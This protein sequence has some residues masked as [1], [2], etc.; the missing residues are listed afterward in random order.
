MSGIVAIQGEKANQKEDSAHAMLETL[1]HRGP[2]RSAVLTSDNV[3]IGCTSMDAPAPFGGEQLISSPDGTRAIAYDGEIYNHQILRQK[4]KDDS[5]ETDRDAETVFRFYEE[6]GTECVEHLDGMFGFVIQ[7]K[8]NIFAARDPLGIKPLYYGSSHGRFYLASEIKAL[9]DFVET[10]REFPP[11]HCYHSKTG[12]S[13]YS[14]ITNEPP[15]IDEAGAAI[16]EIR[17]RLRRSV[18]KRLVPGMKTG[19][20]LSGGVDST[21]ICS[22]VAEELGEIPTF[23]VGMEDSE[24][25]KHAR[26]ASRHI[27][28]EYHELVYG[29]DQILAVLPKVIYYLESFD[30]PLVRSAICNFLASDIAK[31][32]VD[33]VFIGEGGDELFGGYHHIKRFVGTRERLLRELSE[34]LMGLHNIG[35]Q[36]V[37]RMNSAHS[38]VVRAPFFDMSLVNL[39]LDITPELK[40][41]GDKH[42]E[43]WILRKA[44]EDELP[45]EI[46]WR[47]KKQFAYGCGSD[48]LLTQ[49]AER[50]VS[51]EAFETAQRNHP[52]AGLTSKEE[53][54][55]F[56][57]FQRF[58]GQASVISTV[59]RWHE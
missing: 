29:L 56:D 25:L 28:T 14:Q 1:K 24:D 55:Y 13:Q 40:I 43:K 47:R 38:I 36:R 9:V 57:I 22:L 37:D 12:F 8:D 31:E 2:D 51:D 6:T 42:I 3:V 54:L 46:A 44:F 48:D 20:L 50:E 35:F 23:S 10:I 19:A 34:G 4:I 27:G 41:Y 26:I 30:A 32:N 49:Y 53:M 33:V 18:Q 16:P 5:F 21:V 15:T 7:D 17:K 45:E 59:G 39:S 11:G 58:F 52:E